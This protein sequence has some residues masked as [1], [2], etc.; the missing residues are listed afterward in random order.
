MP[1]DE[2]VKAG[3]IETL[4]AETDEKFLTQVMGQAN[5]PETVAKV[6]DTFKV[7]YTPSTAPAIS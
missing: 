7:V 6:A 3:F 5:D 4:G 2:A 1:Y